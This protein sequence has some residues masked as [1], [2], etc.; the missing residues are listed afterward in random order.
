MVKSTPNSDKLRATA[1]SRFHNWLVRVW[2][3]LKENHEP[4]QV[5]LTFGT[6]AVAS[7]LLVET[8]HQVNEAHNQVVASEKQTSIMRE[9]VRKE[10]KAYVNVDSLPEVPVLLHKDLFKW[11]VKNFGQT[12]AYHVEAY[13]QYVMADTS[14][15]PTDDRIVFSKKGHPFTLNRET[16]EAVLGFCPDT[17]S[18]TTPKDKARFIIGKIRFV[19]IFDD[20]TV[21]SFRYRYIALHRKF[22]TDY[23]RIETKE[24]TNGKTTSPR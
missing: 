17:A 11:S 1:K 21:V 5:V 18:K 14:T 4:L 13:A 20:T 24:S 15:P 12:P 9:S 6:I 22:F 3:F 23:N 8:R 7:W 2:R 19:D 16:E 10:L